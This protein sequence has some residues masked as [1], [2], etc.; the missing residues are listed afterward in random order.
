MRSGRTALRRLRLSLS[1]LVVTAVYSV[2]PPG[3]ALASQTS[4]VTASPARTFMGPDGDP[5]PF[6]NDD[7]VM[8]FLETASV[9]GRTDIGTGIHRFKKLTLEKSGVRAH[10]IFRTWT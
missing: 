4:A 2:A 1:L 10:A 7:E 3:L 6:E 9:I 8:E 5:L